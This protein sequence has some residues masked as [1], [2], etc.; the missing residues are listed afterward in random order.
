LRDVSTRDEDREHDGVDADKLDAVD[1]DARVSVLSTC[2][3]I[4]NPMLGPCHV[5]RAIMSIPPA[6]AGDQQAMSCDNEFL[7]K[8]ICGISMSAVSHFID[9]VVVQWP[10]VRHLVDVGL[11]LVD[12]G[13][14]V[15]VDFPLSI[16]VELP[17]GDWG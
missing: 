10:Q 11:Q 7:P 16:S 14:C 15:R 9:L 8:Q 17:R 12:V 3:A 2:T 6:E 13:S 1:S 5:H 4:G